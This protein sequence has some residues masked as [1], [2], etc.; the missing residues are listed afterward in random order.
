MIIKKIFDH[1]ILKINN[2]RSISTNYY[3]IN[4]ILRIIKNDQKQFSI[5]KEKLQ[6][7]KDNVDEYIKK[8]HDDSLQKHSGVSK[9]LPLL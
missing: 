1:N 6:I 7:S 3:Q 4:A 9:T 2:N 8:H 5:N